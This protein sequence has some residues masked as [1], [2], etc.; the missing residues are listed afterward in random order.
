MDPIT[1]ALFMAA[2]KKKQRRWVAVGSSGLVRTSDDDGVTWDTRTGNP[3]G[4]NVLW[5][6]I[7]F[8]QGRFVAVGGS[9]SGSNTNAGM[10]S[11]DGETW[12]PSSY[13][14]SRAA[15]LRVRSSILSGS[16]Y[17]RTISAT[18]NYTFG[19]SDGG[20][21]WTLLGSLLPESN[22]WVGM[23]GASPDGFLAVR[24][25]SGADTTSIVGGTSSG[26]WTQPSSPVAADMRD[27]W[28][29]PGVGA[30][31]ICGSAGSYRVLTSNGGRAAAT[32]W[33]SRSATSAEWQ[34]VCY[35]KGLFVAVGVNA[36]GTAGVIM[37]SPTGVTWTNRTGPTT[38]R[39]WYRVAF[40]K[41]R[42][43]ALAY[44]TDGTT[45]YIMSSLDGIAWTEIGSFA[46]IAHSI[47][48]GEI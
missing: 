38:G 1:H 43:L 32:A 2:S 30:V 9:G 21:N 40:Y 37:T 22:N 15:R 10:T 27:V 23:S 36:A 7:I 33:T 8:A 25:A 13:N 24:Q 45:T 29:E 16:P 46:G 42:F 39:L 5:N 18:D 28:Y 6:D 3:T 4:S 47:C 34:S 11:L 31:A 26:A 14:N 48:G 44:K 19:S 35:G 12:T 41:D 17:L 20:V